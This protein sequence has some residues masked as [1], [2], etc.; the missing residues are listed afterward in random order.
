MGNIPKLRKDTKIKKI[1]QVNPSKMVERA[2]KAY[3]HE[4][5][6]KKT[7]KKHQT[8]RKKSS[9]KRFFRKLHIH[10]NASPTTT[11]TLAKKPLSKTLPDVPSQSSTL[12]RKTERN[13]RTRVAKI[14]AR[15]VKAVA[16]AAQ[17][18]SQIIN[19]KKRQPPGELKFGGGFNLYG[20]E[21]PPIKKDQKDEEEHITDTIDPD[22]GGVADA[23]SDDFD[24]ADV[25]D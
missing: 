8:Q 10:H 3:V 16:E 14:R 1:Y 19:K 24:R 15:R 18:H 25:A 23:I 6:L 22:R 4:M 11:R 17:L 13:F 7:P 5:M 21:G 12:N 2:V 9:E 20:K